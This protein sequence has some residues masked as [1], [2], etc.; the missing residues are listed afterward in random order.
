MKI[1]EVRAETARIVTESRSAN[2]ARGPYLTTS[3]IAAEVGC[4]RPTLTLVLDG[5]VEVGEIEKRPSGRY[6]VRTSEETDRAVRRMG[7]YK[8]ARAV[9][10]IR[11]G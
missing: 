6:Y 5:L 9:I 4:S 8:R 11:R 2:H 1:A 7:A 10:A 3:K